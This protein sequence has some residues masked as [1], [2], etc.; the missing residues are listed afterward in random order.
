MWLD[1]SIPGTRVNVVI[2]N[3]R[4]KWSIVGVDDI[5]IN[6]LVEVH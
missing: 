3:A 2:T 4:F 6:Y 5:P 1:E